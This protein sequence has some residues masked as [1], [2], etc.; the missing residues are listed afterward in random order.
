V[1][2]FAGSVPWRTNAGSLLSFPALL[3]ELGLQPVAAGPASEAAALTGLGRLSVDWRPAADQRPAA[4]SR[5]SSGSL[6]LPRIA[7]GHGRAR[8][9]T[10]I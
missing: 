6:M 5:S 9:T 10:C 1:Q 4:R 3:L 8:I 2:S 7:R